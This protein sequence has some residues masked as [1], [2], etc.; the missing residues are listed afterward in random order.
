MANKT[1]RVPNI[2]CGHCVKTIERELRELEGIISVKAN[3]D[4]K[5]VTVEWDESHTNWNK[6]RELLIE[7]NYLPEE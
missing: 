6:I 1:F 4:N 2:T 5:I 7:I 3:K